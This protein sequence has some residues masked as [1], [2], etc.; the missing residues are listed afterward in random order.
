MIITI[1]GKPGSGKT[2]VGRLVAEQL[3]YKQYDIGILRREMARKRGMTIE[4][5]NTLGETDSS[6]DTEADDYQAELGRTEDN[7]VIQGRT[8]FHFIPNSLK[9]FL[10]VDT[11]VGAERIWGDLKN[12]PESRNQKK[13]DSI[14]SLMKSTQERIDSDNMR[15]AKYYDGLNIFDRSQYDLWL[16]TTETSAEKVVETIVNAAKNHKT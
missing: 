16:N 7:F 9:V 13:H 10:D 6:T 2:T 3:G 4:E 1:S 14:E 8:S 5:Y 11:R 12:D 15:Y